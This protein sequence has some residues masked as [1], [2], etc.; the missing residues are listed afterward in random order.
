MES[1]T[2]NQVT[3]AQI[4]RLEDAAQNPLTAKAWPQGHQNILQGR[5]QLPVYRRY[6]EIPDNS[7]K[8]QVMILSSKTGSGKL[9]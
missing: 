3:A 1:I 2:R 9:T 7:H 5:R 4:Q 6:Q 8:S